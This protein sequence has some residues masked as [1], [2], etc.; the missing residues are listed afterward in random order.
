MS[1]SFSIMRCPHITFRSQLNESL[2]MESPVLPSAV[3]VLNG[4]MIAIHISCSMR[5]RL[6]SLSIFQ[7]GYM[8]VVV[9]MLFG[10]G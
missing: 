4:R 3:A 2:L 9:A 7:V 8:V 5:D 6:L 1:H 10:P